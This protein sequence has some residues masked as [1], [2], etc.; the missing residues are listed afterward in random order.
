MKKQII[1]ITAIF[2]L[3]FLV[4]SVLAS[5]TKVQ[6]SSYLNWTN[7]YN[8]PQQFSGT[9]TGGLVGTLTLT[10]KSFLERIYL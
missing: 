6:G 3:T 2:M 1:A 5:N 8:R 10:T 7:A 4:G 9:T